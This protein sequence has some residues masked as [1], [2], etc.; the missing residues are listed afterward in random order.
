MQIGVFC[1][2]V[3]V[4]RGALSSPTSTILQRKSLLLHFNDNNESK[5]NQPWKAEYVSVTT[6]NGLRGDSG[7]ASLSDPSP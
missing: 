1:V 7:G 5:M 2:T 4:L 3:L 6:F